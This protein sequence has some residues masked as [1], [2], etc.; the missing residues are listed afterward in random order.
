MLLFMV[1][2]I[3]IYTQCKNMILVLGIPLVV[4]TLLTHMRESFQTEGFTP[5]IPVC[6]TSYNM[7]DISKCEKIL[8]MSGDLFNEYVDNYDLSGYDTSGQFFTKDDISNLTKLS[9][10][11]VKQSQ[12]KGQKQC[13]DANIFFRNY[14]TFLT[15][16]SV[17]SFAD[18]TTE[19]DT[20]DET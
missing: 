7:G 6:D 11:I 8:D 2:T 14:Y 12:R 4:I 3:V 10:Y 15:H 20:T 9:D 13:S 1:I 19:E 17:G 16:H 18:E 5:L